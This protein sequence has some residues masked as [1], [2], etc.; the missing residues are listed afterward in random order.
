LS[1]TGPCILGIDPGFASIGVAAIRLGVRG[2]TLLEVGVIRTEGSDKKRKVLASDDNARRG[3]EI[4]RELGAWLDKYK[5]KAIAAEAMSFP[6]NSSAAAKMALTWGVIIAACEARGIALLQASPQEI[7]VA[8]AGAKSATK[9]QVQAGVQRRH[10]A[11]AAK[12][13]GIPRS[14]HE[15]AC[16]AAAAAMTCI[17]SDAVRL[18]RGL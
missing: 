2:D 8:L 13:V 5:P 12:L 16:D 4:A 7:K 11:L 15:H 18:L 3:R 9:E 10:K 6:R 1:A 14:L 17:G